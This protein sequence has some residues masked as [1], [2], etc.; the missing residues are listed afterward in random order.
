MR[1]RGITALSSRVRVS[2]AARMYTYTYTG[3]YYV[4]IY[5]LVVDL[6]VRVFILR[7]ALL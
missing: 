1:T 7:F 2:F 4:R 3:I 6:T 5:Y